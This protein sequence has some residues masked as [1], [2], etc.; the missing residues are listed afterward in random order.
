M[1]DDLKKNITAKETWLRGLFILLFGFL[2]AVGRLVLW[3]V[4]VV[5]FLFTLLGGQVNE[6]LLQFSGSLCRFLYQCFL[7]VT[8]NTDE[9]PFPFDEWPSVDGDDGAG[10]N[11]SKKHVTKR[12][13]AKK[14]PKKKSTVK[15]ASASDS[16][17]EEEGSGK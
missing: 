10:K 13:A 4:V 1:E 12:P 3:T 7:Y 5:Q 8:F 14:K 17:A 15:K 11:E 9:K 6:K 2:L 16:I